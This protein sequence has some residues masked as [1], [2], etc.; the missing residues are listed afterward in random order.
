MS[1]DDKEKEDLAALRDSDDPSEK[2]EQ[3]Y[4]E[5]VDYQRQVQGY[6]LT[7]LRF[8]SQYLR[9]IKSS[10]FTN[11]AHRLFYKIA[12]S[13]YD[14]HQS[15]PSRISLRQEVIDYLYKK[16]NKKETFERAKLI[17]LTELNEIYDFYTKSGVGNAIPFLDTP[18]V[19]IERI[20]KFARAQAIRIALAQIIVKLKD[21]DSD[22]TYLEIDEIYQK[23]R[24]VDRK[25]DLGLDYWNDFDARYQRALVAKDNQNVVTSGFMA[26]DG[27]LSVNGIRVGEIGAIMGGGGAGKSLFLVNAAYKNIA[28]G[29]KVLYITTEMDQDSVGFRFD[30]MI[31][32]IG[33]HKLLENQ[34]DVK[35][36]LDICCYNGSEDRK[37]LVIK[38]FPSGTADIN[39]IKG[40]HAQLKGANFRPDLVIVDYLGDLVDTPG[41]PVYESR[42]RMIRDLRGFGA[43]ESHA[44]MTAIHSRRQDKNKNKDEIIED[45]L[46]EHDIAD[47]HHMFR[48]VDCMWS[49]NC[50]AIERLAG[51][52]TIHIIKHRDG[53]AGENFY[54][55]YG[56]NDQTLRL[57]EIT[58]EKYRGAKQL[59][60]SQAAAG[61]R[62][63]G[64][65][66]K[67]STK[68]RRF[69]PRG[70]DDE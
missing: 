14:K 55:S 25:Q 52:G 41:I 38:Q 2:P 24:L 27:R 40:I 30:S 17:Y 36:M 19:L 9:L 5:E 68:K 12:E 66:S 57:E 70:P 7:D 26:I 62:L 1:L 64:E 39:S 34:I 10:Y 22:E 33:K 49:M 35:R 65:D 60:M 58:K 54:I 56:F 23:A 59:V 4:R 67:P 32:G 3:R 29:K 31:S 18:E 37:R 69:E 48:V 45:V 21:S 63:L 46:T 11:N 51:V 20:T 42:Y 16:F 15:L 50:S 61:H 6:L 44:T 13:Y 47:S 43:I 8:F 53:A 28:R